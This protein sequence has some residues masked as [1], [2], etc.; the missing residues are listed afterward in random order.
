ML[1]GEQTGCRAGNS[2]KEC[3]DLE[4]HPRCTPFRS[5]DY[6]ALDE[7]FQS[8]IAARTQLVTKSPEKLGNYW[9]S[10]LENKL[11]GYKVAAGLG[12]NPPKIIDCSNSLEELKTFPGPTDGSGFVVR[13]TSLHS[14]K[15]I[16][17]FPNGFDDLEL[18][19]DMKMSADDVQVDMKTLGVTSYIVEKY[20][21]GPS[22]FPTEYKF[23]MIGGAVASINVVANRGEDCA[24]KCVFDN[25]SYA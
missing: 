16:Y 25:F 14:N 5:I 6:C 22:V 13:A 2:P 10:N 8:Y 19:R 12:L 21:S 23:H 20:I 7:S 17:V 24:C 9:F 15:G 18:I 4:P 3:A 11:A 1:V